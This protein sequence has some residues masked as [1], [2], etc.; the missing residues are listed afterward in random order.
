MADVSS[1]W[2]LDEL[3]RRAADALAE[4]GVRAPNGRVTP[5]PDRRVVRWYTTIGLVDRP[6]AFRG[7]TALYGSRHLLQVVAVKRRQA[8]GR[9]LAEIQAEL[10]GAT[11]ATLQ[12][13]AQ[14]RPVAPRP[15][16]VPDGQLG[17]EVPE[18]AAGSTR[19]GSTEAGVAEVGAARPRF[20]ADRSAATVD[21]A[22]PSPAAPP[23]IP[24]PVVLPRV[25]PS[26]DSSTMDSVT[27]LY[28]IPLHAGAT[29][30]LH[31]QP[32]PGDLAA[33]HAAARPL[34][35]LLAGRGLLGDV[36]HL[37]GLDGSEGA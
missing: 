26:Y 16:T 22:A 30:L 35:D 13:V 18:F 32:D 2:P 11:D 19:A 23:F 24:P 21:A 28:A 5:L 9:S 29:L 37:D 31:A 27:P 4:G 12:R 10:T 1:G 6:I 15:A 17:G 36:P 3:V 20:W 33:V 14:L 7:R 34:L 8:Q 25:V